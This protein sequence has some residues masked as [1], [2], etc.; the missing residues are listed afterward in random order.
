MACGI[1]ESAGESETLALPEAE[2]EAAGSEPRVVAVWELVEHKVEA[3]LV[4]CV[5]DSC[6][7]ELLGRTSVTDASAASGGGDT[8]VVE[9]G[10]GNEGST[11][12]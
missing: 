2:S 5:G 12:R 10:A 4:G 9:Y 1:S 11:L 7:V 3:R 8:E 6:H